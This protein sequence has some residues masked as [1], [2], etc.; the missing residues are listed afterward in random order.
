MIVCTRQGFPRRRTRRCPKEGC[1]GGF[2][3]V[4]R[5][6]KSLFWHGFGGG[7]VLLFAASADKT[8]EAHNVETK[9]LNK[10]I[11]KRKYA[12]TCLALSISGS[13]Q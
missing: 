5:A 3:P 8:D 4:S 6:G 9:Q 7:D 12:E 11:K 10:Y 1:R 13:I 2:T